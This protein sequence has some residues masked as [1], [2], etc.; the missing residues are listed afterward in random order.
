MER[1]IASFPDGGTI[2]MNPTSSD[3][4]KLG[5]E[6]VKFVRY[7]I[8]IATKKMFIFDADGYLHMDA[9]NVLRKLGILP[10]SN[11]A[12][13]SEFFKR[14]LTGTAK[15]VDGELVYQEADIFDY[16]FSKFKKGPNSLQQN[17]R[18]SY[19]FLKDNLSS[20]IQSCGF[21]DNL[22][23]GCLKPLLKMKELM[24]KQK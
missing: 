2:F 6:K 21:A 4:A 9:F 5:K 16:L 3:F 22:I 1:D 11:P 20:I 17:E 14:Y 15:I 19:L 10:P 7:I 12:N 8:E 23:K 13:Q 18:S 24:D